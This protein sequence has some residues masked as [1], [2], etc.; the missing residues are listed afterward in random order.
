MLHRTVRMIGLAMAVHV[1][2]AKGMEFYAEVGGS[3]SS[4]SC[5]CGMCMF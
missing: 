5:T 3:Q 2:S 4:V 1:F